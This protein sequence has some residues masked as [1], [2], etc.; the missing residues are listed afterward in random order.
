MFLC[1]LSRFLAITP[2]YFIRL[3]P[4]RDVFAELQIDTE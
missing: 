4:A 3:K 1:A 2:D